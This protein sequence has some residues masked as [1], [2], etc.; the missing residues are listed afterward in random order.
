MSAAVKTVRSPTSPPCSA[1]KI[2]DHSPRTAATCF[3]QTRRLHFEGGAS[4]PCPCPAFHPF[5]FSISGVW[6]CRFSCCPSVMDQISHIDQLRRQYHPRSESRPRSRT[7]EHAGRPDPAV[8]KAK[9]R[10][11]TAGWRGRNDQLRRPEANTI[12]MAILK[13]ICTAE[14]MDQFDEKSIVI[15]TKALHDLEARGFSLAETKAV[16]RRLRKRWKHR[17]IAAGLIYDVASV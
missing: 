16:M 8:T 4:P 1:Q 9:D 13:V 5:S 11:R 17:S 15:L 10:F 7:I 14:S 2:S 6:S 12:S 3:A